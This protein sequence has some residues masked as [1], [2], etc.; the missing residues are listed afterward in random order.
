MEHTNLY[1]LFEFYQQSQ[2]E[3]L[4]KYKLPKS[5]NYI[6]ITFYDFGGIII[7][8]RCSEFNYK[9]NDNTT[10]KGKQEMKPVEKIEKIEELKE[11]PKLT[12]AI[13]DRIDES[14]NELELIRSNLEKINNDIFGHEGKLCDD[15]ATND[16][17]VIDGFEQNITEKLE[18]QQVIISEISVI[19][20]KLFKL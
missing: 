17:G 19:V 15:I 20:N 1:N 16:K 18:L 6:K 14:N 7:E 13:L 10:K 12:E 5:L 3:F 9:P 4:K 8:E 11:K 2:T